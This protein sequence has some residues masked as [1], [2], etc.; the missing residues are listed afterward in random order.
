M[1][2]GVL[3]KKAS[4]VGAFFVCVS[5]TACTQAACPRIN[6]LPSLAVQRVVDGD[7]LKLVDGRSVRLIGLNTPELARA[8]RVSEPGAEAARQRLRELVAANGGRIGVQP[9][10]E[11]RDNHGRTLA[12]AYGAEGRN[13]EAQLL[14]EGLGIQVAVPPNLALLECLQAA[15]RQAR[16][17]R[18]GLWRAPVQQVEALARSGF[19]LVQG[20]VE[21]VERNRGGLWLEMRGGLVLRVGPE[22]LE[23]FDLPTLEALVG[24]QVEAR[25]WVIDRGRRGAQSAGRARWLLPLS[26]GAMLEVLP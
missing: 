4:L 9:G 1:G 18:L 22:R 6:D 24:R 19:A 20:K 12:H 10:R 17:A 13:L 14:A 21:G 2:L 8:G 11:S 15:E 3:L 16:A 5:V 26:H 7:T 25:G 23:H